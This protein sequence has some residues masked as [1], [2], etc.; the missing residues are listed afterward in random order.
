M[1]EFFPVDSAFTHWY[2]QLRVVL[3]VVFRWR[4]PDRVGL[5]VALL[6]L[7]APDLVFVLEHPASS[8]DLGPGG[9]WRVSP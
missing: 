5:V 4:G 9:E 7:L 3:S 2:N 6:T 1:K 8:P